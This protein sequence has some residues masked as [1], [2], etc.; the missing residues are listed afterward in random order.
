L[1]FMPI[2]DGQ[3]ILYS[4]ESTPE[5]RISV[6]FGSGSQTIPATELPG[7]ST[8]LEKSF[9][10][11]LVRTMVEPRR[12][13]FSLPAVNLKK[14]AV[15]GIISVTV[16]SANNL[17]NLNTKGFMADRRVNSHGSSYSNGSGSSSGGGSVG[18]SGNGNGS[19]G[20]SGSGINLNTFVEVELGDLTR[21][22][23]P[24]WGS[25]PI[26]GENFNMVLHE[27]IGTLKLHLFEQCSGNVKYDRL[28]SCEIKMKY[29]DDD[30]T[31]FWAIGRESSVSAA[32]AEHCGKEVTMVVPFEGTDSAEIT[33]KLVIREWQFAGDSRNIH[34]RS[35]ASSQQS[36]LGTWSSL[37]SPTGR[38]LKIT[39]LEGRNLTGK[40]R[41]G[42][43]DPYIKLQY[44]KI[45][46]RTKSIPR[47]LNPIWGQE[48]EFNET[49]D[50]EYLGTKIKCYDEEFLGDESMG[51]ARVNLDGLEVGVV[52]DVW[53]PLEKIPTGE[54]RLKIEVQKPDQ[55]TDGRQLRQSPSLFVVIFAIDMHLNRA[56]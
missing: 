5:V 56:T 32:R 1:R 41:S 16:V 27:N 4:F 29:V 9:T 12:K 18:I 45:I 7:V 3:A 13:C 11:T 19:G 17:V 2:L 37:Q 26:W 14:S 42:K 34:S 38:K 55:A 28:A 22:T 8:W 50:G 20:G 6:A 53:V 25:T 43:S 49:G 24:C 39:V 36:T 40:D 21:R 15:G 33:V 52:K 54:V 35:T 48:F 31:T 44:G 47:D 23:T 10:E 51:S 46:R 30:S